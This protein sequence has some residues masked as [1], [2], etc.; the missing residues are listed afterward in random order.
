MQKTSAELLLGML[1]IKIL[2]RYKHLLLL[3]AVAIFLV[4]LP[5]INLLFVKNLDWRD[6]AT[7][8]GKGTWSYYDARIREIVNGHPFMGNPYFLEHNNEIAPAFFLADWLAAIPRLLGASLEGGAT[9]NLLF[10]SL[11]FVFLAYGILREM[12]VSK[13]TSVIGAGL[14]YFSVFYMMARPVSMQIVFPFYLFFLLAFLFWIKDTA[15][16]KRSVLLILAATM[17][18]YIYTYL[19]Q[20]V[21]IILGLTGMYWLITKENDKVIGLIKRL[22][23]III[24]SAPLF[25]YTYMQISH[26]YYWETM[27]RMGFM[28]THMPF[29]ETFYFGRWIILIILIWFLGFWWSK[30]LKANQ[31]YKILFI[32]VAISGLSLIMASASNII[33]GKDLE[34][35]EHIVRFVWAWAPLML[36]AFL[37]R[38]PEYSAVYR[39][40][41]GASDQ[42]IGGAD[43]ARKKPALMP[44]GTAPRSGS[45]FVKD[46]WTNFRSFSLS[47][48]I[49]ILILC[50]MCFFGVGIY[51]KRSFLMLFRKQQSIQSYIDE[52]QRSEAVLEWLESREKK[53]VVIWIDDDSQSAIEGY[54]TAA[55]KHYVLFSIGGTLHLVS[56]Q[57]VEERYLVSNYFNKLS[58]A[59]LKNDFNLYAGLADAVHLYKT[60]NRK[61]I[62][63]RFF[64][65]DKLGYDCGEKTDAFTLK[66]EKYF[67]DLYDQYTKEIVPNIGR[68]LKKYHVAYF[69][70]DRRVDKDIDAE[71]IGMERAY[72]D[73]NFEVYKIK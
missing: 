18:F 67:T 3:V 45:F 9:I 69:I 36:V 62:L 61:V 12:G 4:F 43:T 50:L 59:D 47:K 29:A 11:V 27:R 24:F 48:R 40:D 51:Y 23:L 34:L 56:N 46:N 70:K 22:G 13:I 60:H 28:T 31:Q 14:S 72:Y 55:T 73:D 32:F 21:V 2:T 38:E 63:C 10:W 25:V 54:I 42:I 71:K 17:S 57:E 53:P 65:L 20:I 6:V 16:K 33:T 37:L 39:G 26:P 19:W 44:R 52:N 8:P 5:V 1:I 30:E 68:Y 64:Q 66:G 49:V 7:M 41:E 35:A 58:L 15:N